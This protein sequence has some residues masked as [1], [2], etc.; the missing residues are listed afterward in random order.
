MNRNQAQVSSFFMTPLK[1]SESAEKH[2][3]SVTIITITK[4]SGV[5]WP[6]RK[7]ANVTIKK[8]C[9]TGKFH[10]LLVMMTGRSP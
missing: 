1:S 4:E 9:V 5:N 8:S 10:F 6:K 7:K 3:M 2:M